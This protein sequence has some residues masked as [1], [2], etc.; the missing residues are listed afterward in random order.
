MPPIHMIIGNKYIQFPLG[1]LLSLLSLPNRGGR[2]IQ[3]PLLSSSS[4]KF[5]FNI[6]FREETLIVNKVATQLFPLEEHQHQH[7]HPFPPTTS[8]LGEKEEDDD[9]G[10]AVM[11]MMTRQTTRRRRRRDFRLPGY[12]KLEH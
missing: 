10:V 5:D 1:S 11:M 3:V 2:K 12:C 8:V 7:L 6:D 4:E 9:D